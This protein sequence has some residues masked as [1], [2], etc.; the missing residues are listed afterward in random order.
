MDPDQ[1]GNTSPAG[2]LD[3]SAN[4]DDWHAKWS[5]GIAVLEDA[6]S[7]R[8]IYHPIHYTDWVRHT[9]G[10]LLNLHMS[11]IG[12]W[13]WCPQIVSLLKKKASARTV[14]F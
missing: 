13:A 8:N 7:S 4:G 9:V 11:D 12:R 3:R 2:P 5:Q 10:A 14:R 1:N 6:N